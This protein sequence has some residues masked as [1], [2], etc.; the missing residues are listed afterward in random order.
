MVCI[1]G[2]CRHSKILVLNDE[3]SVAGI[4]LQLVAD[5]RIFIAVKAITHG[6]TEEVLVVVVR[7]Q[8]GTTIRVDVGS[9]GLHVAQQDLTIR[10]DEEILHR[11]AVVVEVKADGECLGVF[12]SVEVQLAVAVDQQ[13]RE[14]FAYSSLQVEHSTTCDV[15]VVSL[16]GLHLPGKHL[17]LSRRCYSQKCRCNK[18]INLFHKLLVLS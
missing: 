15:G 4:T 12:G 5:L 11:L 1:P 2:C 9:D 17:G 6:E 10:S 16:G 14:I 3:H 7:E 18:R 13:V 8:I